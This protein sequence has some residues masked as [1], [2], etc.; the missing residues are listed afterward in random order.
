MELLTCIVT[1]VASVHNLV[2]G[3]S[4]ADDDTSGVNI[5]N[6]TSSLRWCLS[7]PDV[8]IA[9]RRAGTRHELWDVKAQSSR[10]FN[11]EIRKILR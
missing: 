8:G 1:S 11:N 9:C 10:I 3:T 4:Y 7:G 2:R 6:D 5:N